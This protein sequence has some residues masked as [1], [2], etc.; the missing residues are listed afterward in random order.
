MIF[1]VISIGDPEPETLRTVASRIRA[2]PKHLP[3]QRLIPAPD[4]G[5]KYILRAIASP[6]LRHSPKSAAIVRRLARRSLDRGKE[7]PYFWST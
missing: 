7:N 3:P 1:R 6:N 4:C 2:A 5:M